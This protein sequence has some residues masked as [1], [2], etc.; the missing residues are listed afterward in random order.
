M[1]NGMLSKR[2]RER[3]R[4]AGESAREVIG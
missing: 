2:E 4:E 3:A 1:E